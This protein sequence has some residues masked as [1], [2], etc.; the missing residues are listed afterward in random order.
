M[1]QLAASSPSSTSVALHVTRMADERI[2]QHLK[3]QR[4]AAKQEI[5]HLAAKLDGDMLVCLGSAPHAFASHSSASHSSA[6]TNIS[7]EVSPARARE[8]RAA[9]ESVA[10]LLAKARARVHIES[11][12]PPLRAPS[13]PDTVPARNPA[14]APLP[15]AKSV[16]ADQAPVLDAWVADA[17]QRRAS[18]A[19]ALV[20]GSRTLAKNKAVT[21][22]KLHLGML[23][24]T[25]RDVRS[26]VDGAPGNMGPRALLDHVKRVA[27]EQAAVVMHA[28]AERMV[29]VAMSKVASDAI[30]HGESNFALAYSAILVSVRHP[31]F[32]LALRAA[33]ESAC[34]FAVPG[35]KQEL[36][37]A[38]AQDP[39]LDRRQQL[40]Y[41]SGEE[42]DADYLCRMQACVAFYAALLQTRPAV[43]GDFDGDVNENPFCLAEAWRF[44]AGTLNGQ[45]WRWTRFVLQAFLAV[46]GFELSLA[47]GRQTHKLVRLLSSREFHA[48]CDKSALHPDDDD[49]VAVFKLVMQDAL[50]LGRLPRPGREGGDAAAQGW[51]DPRV[52]PPDV[53]TNTG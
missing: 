41:A 27:P 50:A 32:V 3:A 16:P 45:M 34:P 21:Q 30:K 15:A 48:A 14:Q 28:V 18:H 8:S 29:R 20:L 26:R 1:P 44:L 10:D 24:G 17:M 51:L 13:P 5:L 53:I 31:E 39:G 19:Q 40:G 11:T 46:A 52:L 43:L 33:M 25:V 37:M 7:P 36:E 49:R 23:S 42:T 35:L 47:L 4:M 22:C 9:L 2:A 6:P 38:C 12:R